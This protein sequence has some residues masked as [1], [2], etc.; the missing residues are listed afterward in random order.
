METCVAES[1]CCA[2]T[3]SGP[4]KRLICAGNSLVY[5]V[6]RVRSA[7]LPKQHCC[8]ERVIQHSRTRRTGSSTV[9]C[10]LKVSWCCQVAAHNRGEQTAWYES[11]SFTQEVLSAT[12]APAAELLEELEDEFGAHF[13]RV[14]TSAPQH[15]HVCKLQVD[16]STNHQACAHGQ[17]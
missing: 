12:G 10:W 5:R 13:G 11:M 3:C 2:C 6:T 4:W 8:S 15:A 9:F 14:N 17:T 1:V 7:F 16:T